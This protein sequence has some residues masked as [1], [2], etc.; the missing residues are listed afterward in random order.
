M[1]GVVRSLTCFL[2]KWLTR[3]SIADVADVAESICVTSY[4]TE[5]NLYRVLERVMFRVLS[6]DTTHVPRAMHNASV[7]RTKGS[8]VVYVVRAGDVCGASE[9][10]VCRRW[11]GW[12]GASC[13]TC[14]RNERNL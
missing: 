3:P 11:G 1:H 4:S 13:G 2:G 14:S 5:L 12:M 10:G 8:G 9:R 6:K 7:F